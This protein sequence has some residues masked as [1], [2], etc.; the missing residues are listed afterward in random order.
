[1]ADEHEFRVDLA[2]ALRLAARFGFHEGICNHFS[3]MLPGTRDRFLINPWG[4]HWA[5]IRASDL[6]LADDRGRVIT[7]MNKI[8][9]T[10]LFIHAAI[11]RLH[12]AATAVLHTHMPYSTALTV[13]AGGRLEPVS[14]TALR[15]VDRIAYDDTY[16]GLALD[17]REGER[18]AATMGDK[19]VAFLASH[20]IVV[21]GATIAEAFDDLYYL[22]RAAELQV[23]AAGLG[24]GFNAID[25]VVIA[26]TAQQ[27]AAECP[28]QAAR[29][30][31]ALKRLL[32]R[33]DPS[34]AT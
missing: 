25:P 4:F 29:H 9:P 15:F 20:G 19:P 18:I 34:Y 3:V 23:L 22:E 13:A 7:G 1:M 21:T 28:P 24:R 16:N 11:H 10:A 12:P 26:T 2:A 27:M 14:Q 17:D 31:A 30:F 33:D 5:E 32:D 8:E 6:V